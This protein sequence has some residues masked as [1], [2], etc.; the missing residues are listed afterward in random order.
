[1]TQILRADKY[2]DVYLKAVKKIFLFSGFSS[3]EI[4]STETCVQPIT[5]HDWLS[6]VHS[7]E[8]QHIHLPPQSG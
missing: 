2:N 3:G 8:R 5:S 4:I 7:K 1:V 6:A